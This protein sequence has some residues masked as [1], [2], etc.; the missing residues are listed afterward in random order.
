MNK[1]LAVATVLVLI[2]P[3]VAALA[4]QQ[5]QDSQHHAMHEEADMNTTQPPSVHN[6]AVISSTYAPDGRLWT[7]WAQGGHVYVNFS[8][9][10]GKTFS[11]P[12]KANRFAEKLMA[13][14]E[15][16]PK[17]AVAPNGNI[18]IAYTQKLP[19]KYTGNIRFSRSSDGGKTFSTAITVNSDKRVIS[20]RFESMAVNSKGEIFIAWLDARDAA[21]AK[22]KGQEYIGSALYYA[23]STDHG[24][25]FSRNIKIQDH[26]CQCCRTAMAIDRHGM[27]VILW[28]HVFLDGQG[29]NIRDHALVR[30]S[31][32][33]QEGVLHIPR[34]S[35]V[36]VDNWLMNACPHHGPALFIGE[37][38]TYHLTW[39]T[40]ATGKAGLHYAYSTDQ[41]K[42][43]SLPLH[44]GKAEQQAQHP[45]I[46][47]INHHVYL[48]WKT[49]DGEQSALMVMASQD[50]GKSW[51]EPHQ[52]AQA[53]GP[54]DY[55]F[56]LHKPDTS[57]KELKVA[58]LGKEQGFR[59]IDVFAKAP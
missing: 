4:G 43:F 23:V 14:H 51:D 18:Y 1:H 9:N 22:K 24:K 41:G 48:V 12:V 8:D 46:M 2:L 19:K 40:G 32:T 5:Y 27:P 49:F 34:P 56:F 30:L 10:D 17:I 52:I 11:K 15:S 29:E 28:R 37:D 25:S 38:D 47:A 55:P 35:R 58:W 45:D 42:S 36:A 21:D 44:Y 26:T 7:A 13:H 33:R 59:V 16:R 57:Y 39:F 54:T 6:A 50:S 20:H 3:L 53:A 31:A